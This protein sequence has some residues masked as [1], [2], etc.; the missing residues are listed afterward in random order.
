MDIKQKLTELKPALELKYF[1][2]SLGLFGSI[3]RDDFR[4]DSDIDILVDFARPIG[5]EFVDLPE[6]WEHHFQRP[7]DLVARN[8]I[9]NRHFQW[10]EP[11]IQYV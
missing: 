11:D 3:V 1:V 4:Q 8:G 10:I 6:L 2:S 5:I 9:Q 7:V